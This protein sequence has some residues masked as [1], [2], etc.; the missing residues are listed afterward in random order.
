[1]ADPSESVLEAPALGDD[2]CALSSLPLPVAAALDWAVRPECGAVVTFTGTVRDHA[3]GRS[4]VSRLE[5]EA[6]DTQVLPVLTEIA[7]DVRRRWPDVGRV[8]L[9]HR[10]GEVDLGAVSVVVVV[11]APHRG[12]AFEAAKHA[13]DTLKRT[14]PIWKREFW[15]GQQAWGLGSSAIEPVAIEP[16]VAERVDTR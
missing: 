7:A 15:D 8:A 10:V 1:V 13:I 11:S 2:W 9:L 12:E 4:G 5:Y 3:E 6:Y 16:V 14:V